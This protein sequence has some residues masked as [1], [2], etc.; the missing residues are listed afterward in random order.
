MGG[1]T[2]MRRKPRRAISILATVG[3]LAGLLA[4]TVSASAF[5]AGP[6][7]CLVMNTTLGISYDAARA[8]ETLPITGSCGGYRAGH[9]VSSDPAAASVPSQGSGGYRAGHWVATNPAAASVPSQGSGGY[10]AGHWVATNPAAASVPSQGS[11]GYRAGQWV[12]TNPAAASVPSQG[13][14]GYRA[15][16]W[17]P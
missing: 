1:L 7:G 10:R 15:G 8:G 9:W 17:V 5:A 2:R 6:T 12:A 13:S 4:I 14:G 3:L 16:H 11:G